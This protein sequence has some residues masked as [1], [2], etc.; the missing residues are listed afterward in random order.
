MALVPKSWSRQPEKVAAVEKVARSRIE[1][2]PDSKGRFAKV[3]IVA[4]TDWHSQ[5]FDG[6]ASWDDWIWKSVVEVDYATRRPRFDGFVVCN[7]SLGRANAGI[8][9]LALKQNRAVLAIS[10]DD[11]LV[12]VTA[13]TT[14]DPE[15]WMGGWSVRTNN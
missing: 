3:E 1:G 9:D 2:L 13:V 4:S 12:A 6:C 11:R 7:K 15:D 8:V 14:D 10:D 5:T